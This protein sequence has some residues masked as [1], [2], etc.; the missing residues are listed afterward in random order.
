V[1]HKNTFALKID[2]VRTLEQACADLI[3][4]LHEAG[5]NDAQKE[6]MRVAFFLGAAQSYVTMDRAV[7]SRSNDTLT[8]VMTRL[9]G[10]ID[11]FMNAS[12][13]G[14]PEGHA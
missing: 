13:M 4:D 8:R 5:A 9:V 12:A 10:E 6:A 2:G 11:A 1:T 14:E 7:R 3:H